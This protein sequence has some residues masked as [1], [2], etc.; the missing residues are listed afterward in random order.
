MSCNGTF[1]SLFGSFKTP[2]WPDSYPSE[3]FMCVWEI[4][5]DNLDASILIEFQEP[6]GIFGSAPCETDYV[7]VLRGVGSNTTS[8]GKNCGTQ[9]P[10]RIVVEANRATVFFR[11]ST[12]SQMDRPGVSVVYRAI[13]EG[14]TNTF[15]YKT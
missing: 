10:G 4:M 1:M 6:Y 13:V 5:I 14:Y 15:M 8:I 11:G 12:H 3:D 7:E 9:N 2:D